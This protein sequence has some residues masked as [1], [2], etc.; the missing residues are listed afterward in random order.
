M[1]KKDIAQLRKSLSKGYMTLDA[2][3]GAYADGNGGAGSPFMT[4]TVTLDESVEASYTDFV[5]KVIGTGLGKSVHAISLASQNEALIRFAKSPNE[6]KQDGTA[7]IET[8]AAN[9]IGEPCYI[10][11]G[12]LTYSVI[13][14]SSDG[15]TLEDGD[16]VCHLICCAVCP[17]KTS[18]P[19]L[20][21]DGSV[22]GS[23]QRLEIKK[24]TK[25]FLYPVVTDGVEDRNEVLV[26]SKK[27]EE[28]TTLTP[29]FDI[30]S[31]TQSISA[32]AQK[33]LVNDLIDQMN[34]TT[35]EII[36]L[37]DSLGVAAEQS[38]NGVLDEAMVRHA[39]TEAGIDDNDLHERFTASIGN[40]TIVTENVLPKN[41]SIDTGMCRIIAPQEN[42][43]KIKRKTVDGIDCLVVPADGVVL[44]NGA[45]S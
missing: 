28:D 7:C 21:Y 33:N 22:K 26:L 42:L 32:E 19:G 8:I 3:Y 9:I 31:A 36:S 29:V 5:K 20:I 24:P 12:L 25:G 16:D 39:M 34:L 23:P 38:G 1:K 14:K 45:G 41:A 37:T 18:A 11:L 27:P 17:V 43:M 10:F 2:I 40:K 30:S 4:K 44:V 13:A 15:T 6:H 35:N